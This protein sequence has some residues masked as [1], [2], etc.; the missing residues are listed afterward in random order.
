IQ[1]PTSG[2][3]FCPLPFPIS[4]PIAVTR[5][6]TLL[7]SAHSSGKENAREHLPHRPLSMPPHPKIIKHSYD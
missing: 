3:I 2:G 7:R 1:L 5:R 6:C 4:N